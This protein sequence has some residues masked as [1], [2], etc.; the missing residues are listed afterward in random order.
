M[1]SIQGTLPDQI[2]DS[3]AFLM[4]HQWTMPS[5]EGAKRVD[6][7]AYSESVFREIITNAIVH[8]D[9]QKMY[10]PIKIAIFTDRIEVESLGGLLPGL[11]PLS[12]IHKKEWRNPTLANLMK[13]LKY[14]E[15]DGQGI[16]RIYTL[17]RRLK[18]PGPKFVDQD[19]S[20]KV[21]LSGPKDFQQFTY[22]EKQLTLIIMLIIDDFINNESIRNA[23]GI[24]NEQAGTLIKST[25][26]ANI[27]IPRNNSRKFAKYELTPQWREKIYGS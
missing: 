11:T 18:V 2:N 17:S 20:F 27:I 7:P 10:Q 1:V 3:I 21:I 16:A 4:Q 25:L 22:E 15:M 9:Y 12:L 24:T 26:K 8:R 6:V 14:G 5:I 13:K 19:S 23:F